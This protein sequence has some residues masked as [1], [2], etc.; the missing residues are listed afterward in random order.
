MLDEA[1]QFLQ[2]DNGV[3]VVMTSNDIT[4]LP[5]EFT[6]SGRVDALW[7]FGLPTYEERKEIFR[8]HLGKTGKEVTD[9]LIVAGAQNSQDFTGAEIKEVVKVALRKVYKRYKE[10]GNDNITEN[11][12]IDATNEVIPVSRSSR[13]V[14]A[15]LEDWAQRRARYSNADARTKEHK[16]DADQAL[17]EELE[18]EV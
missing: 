8:V 4:Q 15:Q 6:R 11:D 3:F 5:T 16:R 10:D 7:Y 2:K 18:M 17:L 1:L 14:I 12:L 13:E 9:K